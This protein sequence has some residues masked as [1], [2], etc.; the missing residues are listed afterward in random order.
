[1]NEPSFAQPK[2]PYPAQ[3]LLQSM[4]HLMLR[5]ECA[6]LCSQAALQSMCPPSTVPRVCTPELRR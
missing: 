3:A 4:G 6:T 2:D 1:M 5:N